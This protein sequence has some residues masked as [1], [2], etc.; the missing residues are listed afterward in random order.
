MIVFNDK[1][2]CAEGNLFHRDT[3]Q[4]DTVRFPKTD[5]A[6]IARG[7][8][9]DAVTVRDLDD[10]APLADWLDGSRDRPL[11]IDAKIVRYPSWMMLRN[12][13]IREGAESPAL[14]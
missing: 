4:L 7:F 10:L 9:C 3:A 13:A 12:P 5:I 14:A 1:A 2:Y 6:A 11:V 8:G